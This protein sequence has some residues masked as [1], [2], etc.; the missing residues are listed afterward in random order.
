MKLFRMY[1]TYQGYQN[2]T[3][4]TCN[5]RHSILSLLIVEDFLDLSPAAS[6]F[7]A[8]TELSNIGTLIGKKSGMQIANLQNSN[9]VSRLQLNECI[10]QEHL[11]IMTDPWNLLTFDHQGSREAPELRDQR[12]RSLQ[13]GKRIAFDAYR[14]SSKNSAFL[15]IRHPLPID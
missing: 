10:S 4:Y 3:L 2:K 13:M 6:H 8:A 11:I 14:I 5:S 12:R 15:I 7:S 9:I 1:I